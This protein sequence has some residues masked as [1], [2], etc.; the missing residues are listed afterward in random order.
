MQA[1]SDPINIARKIQTLLEVKL[2]RDELHAWFCLRRERDVQRQYHTQLNCIEELITG[3]HTALQPD[4]D[5]LD[6]NA[7]ADAFYEACR[8]IDLRVLWLR[9]VWYFFKDKFD[10]RD[11]P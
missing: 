7:E 10:Q 1:P 5:H 6:T 3:A 4:F 2:L 11:D 9:R 8:L